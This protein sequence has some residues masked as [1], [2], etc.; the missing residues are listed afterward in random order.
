MQASWHKLRDKDVLHWAEG[1]IA[2]GRIG[3]LG[4]SFHDPFET[5]QEIIDAYDHWVMCQFMYNFM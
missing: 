3:H 5:L 4:F 1:A 2:D